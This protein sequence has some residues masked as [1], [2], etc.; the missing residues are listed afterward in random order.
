MEY[1]GTILVAVIC[2]WL[3]YVLG[4]IKGRKDCIK[5]L[6]AGYPMPEDTVLFNK[7]VVEGRRLEKEDCLAII[8]DNVNRASRCMD[9]ATGYEE[10]PY[11]DGA[12]DMANAIRR[13][14]EKE[15]QKDE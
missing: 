6:T 5:D 9:E 11:W 1:I 10:Y 2:F 8:K 14:I 7:G 12:H 13:E 15:E 3:G 4:R